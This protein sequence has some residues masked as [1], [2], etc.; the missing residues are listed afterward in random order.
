LRLIVKT[1]IIGKKSKQNKLKVLNLSLHLLKGLGV[2]Y[3][4]TWTKKIEAAIIVGHATIKIVELTFLIALK[5]KSNFSTKYLTKADRPPNQIT[6][7]MNSKKQKAYSILLCLL[8]DNHKKKN[9]NMKQ[10][11]SSLKI[12]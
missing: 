4:K 7:N 3:I 5:I 10:L 12:F 8:N 2:K 11:F 6:P 1:S 9:K